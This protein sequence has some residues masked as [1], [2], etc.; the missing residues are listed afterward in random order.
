LARQPQVPRPHPR[1]PAAGGF[2]ESI[3]NAGDLNGDG[4]NDFVVGAPHNATTAR[5]RC[6][7]RILRGPGLDNTPDL[8]I[9]GAA[10]G[11]QFGFSLTGGIDF[12]SDGQ[13]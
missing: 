7:L 10:A 6:G 12:N 8:T 9:L 1:R 3:S 11:D 13:S 4:Y 2:G 5:T